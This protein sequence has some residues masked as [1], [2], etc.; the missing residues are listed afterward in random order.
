MRRGEKGR[1]SFLPGCRVLSQ[2][3]CPE[4]HAALE[5]LSSWWKDKAPEG[6]TNFPSLIHTPLSNIRA[7]VC[8]H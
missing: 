3:I 4:I 2:S 8:L 7:A 6:A 5:S 1:P